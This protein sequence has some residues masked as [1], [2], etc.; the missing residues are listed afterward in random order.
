[1]RLFVALCCLLGGVALAQKPEA[2]AKLSCPWRV[3]DKHRFELRQ[4]NELHEK[5]PVTTTTVVIDI[6]VV[7][8]NDKGFVLNW[9]QKE[10]RVEMGGEVMFDAE[11]DGETAKSGAR[12]V[13]DLHSRVILPLQSDAS[14]KIES[15]ADVARLDQSIKEAF[16]KFFESLP[17]RPG[18]ISND[19]RLANQRQ[20]LVSKALLIAEVLCAGFDVVVKD[21]DVVEKPTKI[22]VGML[23]NRT[24]SGLTK[25]EI[26]SIDRARGE[27]R[28]RRT[29]RLDDKGAMDVAIAAEEE[30]AAGMEREPKREGLAPHR[31]S[32]T[33]EARLAL[34]S[35]IPLESTGVLRTESGNLDMKQKFAIRYLPTVNP[36]SRPTN[37]AASQPSKK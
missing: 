20:A 2:P 14:G 22:G 17:R 34:T 36:A 29:S 32:M 18:S 24:F 15:V 6:E 4:T 5:M 13:S 25:T 3:G 9:R 26:L 23:P 12:E 37:P 30:M 31:Q 7:R 21:G 10:V 8:K 11:K 1:M 16:G 33:T 19:E 35:G 28:V 27:M